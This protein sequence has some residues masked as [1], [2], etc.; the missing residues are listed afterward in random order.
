[1]STSSPSFMLILSDAFIFILSAAQ[2]NL[3]D[4]C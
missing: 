3:S 4:K 1:M 2:G